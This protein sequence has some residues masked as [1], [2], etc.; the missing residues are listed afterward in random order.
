METTVIWDAIMLIMTPLSCVAEHVYIPTEPAHMAQSV[1]FLPGDLLLYV[2]QEFAVKCQTL[3]PA[4]RHW[5]RETG[6]A[7]RSQDK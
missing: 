3:S 4:L 7:Q 2:Y 1:E 5:W 6:H